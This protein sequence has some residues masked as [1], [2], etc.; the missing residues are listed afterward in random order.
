MKKE[1]FMRKIRERGM[2]IILSN[3]PLFDS[4]TVQSFRELKGFIKYINFDCQIKKSGGCKDWPDSSNCCCN[5]CLSSVGYFQQMIDSDFVYYARRFNA[6][7]GFWRKEKGCALPHKMR[8]V[9]CL[10]HHCNYKN[11]KH[12]TKDLEGFSTGMVMIKERLNKL[13]KDL[14]IDN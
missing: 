13:R 4:Y 8:S 12:C 6:K 11:H 5:D 3:D 2:R 10:T 1:L 7:T 9:T 14:Y